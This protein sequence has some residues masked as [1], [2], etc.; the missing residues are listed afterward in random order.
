MVV[1]TRQIGVL[2]RVM[3]ERMPLVCFYEEYFLIHIIA[4][5]WTVY[6]YTQTARIP[7][8]TSESNPGRHAR[9]FVPPPVVAL[10]CFRAIG[11]NATATTY[12]RVADDS[13]AVLAPV[14]NDD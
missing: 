4:L 5:P 11:C 9:G 10:T 14:F 7:I 8:I 12:T 6:I 13:S 2:R 1:I 3:T